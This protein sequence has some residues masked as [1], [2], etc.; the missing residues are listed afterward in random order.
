MTPFSQQNRNQKASA[1]IEC[2]E[3]THSYQMSS[4]EIPHPPLDWGSY[5][6]YINLNLNLTIQVRIDTSYSQ[7]YCVHAASNSA[8]Q[9]PCHTDFGRC[10]SS[11]TKE[12]N[13]TEDKQQHTTR[14]DACC[15][16]Y[17]VERID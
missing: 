9:G 12:L 17:L 16:P 1:M 15:K 13:F 6:A 14:Y 10:T 8:N 2:E 3:M 7:K 11:C 5:R 4:G